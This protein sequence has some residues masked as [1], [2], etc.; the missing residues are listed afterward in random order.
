MTDEE[1]KIQ[2]A[3][4]RERVGSLDDKIGAAHRRMDGM[5]QMVREDL[6]AI[7]QKLDGLIAHMNHSK[8][9]QAAYIVVA[10]VLGTVIASGV[11][12]MFK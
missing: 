2:L 3:A 6:K 10:G 12:L 11:Q 9:A 1:A 4:I 8:G 5:D 7:Y